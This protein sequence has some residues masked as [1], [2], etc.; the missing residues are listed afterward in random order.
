MTTEIPRQDTEFVT[1][2]IQRLQS[3]HKEEWA[4]NIQATSKLD[5]FARYKTEL[6]LSKYLSHIPNP[7]HRAVLAKL[8]TTNHSLEIELGRHRNIPRMDRACR[9]CKTGAVETEQ[10]FLLEC[11]A[12]EDLRHQLFCEIGSLPCVT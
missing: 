7:F 10:H 8:R 4:Y 11:A 6:N 5:S 3:S 12:Y 9:I 2:F 1:N